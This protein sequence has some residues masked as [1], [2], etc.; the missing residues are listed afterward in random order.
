MLLLETMLLHVMGPGREQLQICC[1][2]G[3]CAIWTSTDSQPLE[4]WNS[5]ELYHSHFLPRSQ[6]NA[7]PLERTDGYCCL[8]KQSQFATSIIR[9]TVWRF[10]Y[11]AGL[12]FTRSDRLGKEVLFHTE[13]FVGPFVLMRVIVRKVVM[14][15]QFDV[16]NCQSPIPVLLNWSPRTKSKVSAS[17]IDSTQ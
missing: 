1:W 4:A 6:H 17:W 9:N 8:G 15:I 11:L 13:S 16:T 10:W 14:G 3:P 7:S 2:V 12:C 5:F